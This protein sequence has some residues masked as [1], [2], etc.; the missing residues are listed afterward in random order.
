[1]AYYYVDPS[2]T[3]GGD[4]GGGGGADPTVEA[5]WT[6]AYLTL[7]QAADAAAAGDTVFC[8]G[9]EV[10]AA[11]CDFDTNTGSWATPIKF[12]GLNASGVDDGT[13]YVL[14]GNSAAVNCIKIIEK[15]FHF[16]KN[17]ELKNSTIDGVANSGGFSTYWNVYSHHHGSDGF[18]HTAVNESCIFF[19][20]CALNNVAHGF[21]GWPADSF[22]AFC[23]SSLNGS[24]GYAQ[25]RGLRGLIYKCIAYD[26]SSYGAYGLARYQ[27]VIGCTFDDN[28]V[29][30][31]NFAVS[32]DMPHIAFNRLTNSPIGLAHTNAASIIYDIYNFINGNTT[33]ISA[34]GGYFNAGGE[35][36]GTQGYVA[37][38]SGNLNL[39]ATATLRK[40]KL[41][42]GGTADGVNTSFETAG[43]IPEESGG[44]GGTKSRFG[45][46]LGVKRGIL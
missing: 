6:D 18:Y 32:N 29:K 20:C 46:T 42:V 38:G 21:N 13:P 30:N 5:E 24:T 7:Q 14:D 33:D 16:F 44:G 15:Y 1:M 12:I 34:S 4:S 8:R 26:N 23:D 41:L 40:I 37:Q 27:H 36:T 31:L 39:D 25:N 22:F 19:Q 11:T 10:L 9:T 3:A 28:G 17:F 43:Q 2:K 45:E 35:T